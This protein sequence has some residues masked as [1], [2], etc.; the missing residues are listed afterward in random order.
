[1][2]KFPSIWAV[3]FSQDMEGGSTTISINANP[4]VSVDIPV[5]SRLVA[6][7]YVASNYVLDIRYA[8]K[9]PSRLRKML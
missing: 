4:L 2:G 6:E 8:W 1:M 7:I 9:Q 5:L 3:D